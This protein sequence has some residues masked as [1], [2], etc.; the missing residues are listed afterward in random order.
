MEAVGEGE[1]ATWSRAELIAA[2][3]QA[4]ATVS[5]AAGGGSGGS[6]KPA[7]PP[8]PDK[9]FD[10]SRY[11]IRKIALKVAYLGWPYYGLAS[12][13]HTD[14]T[15]EVAERTRFGANGHGT[16]LTK[17]ASLRCALHGSGSPVQG[18]DQG[19]AHPG[20]RLGQLHPLR[21]HGPRRQRI[22]PGT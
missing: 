9:P 18:I 3:R 5:A 21:P 20:P 12:Q 16:R 17:S 10:F 6:A 7:K 13:D 15:V 14:E 2:L 19:Q 4:T 11:A 8:K 22:L 1:Y